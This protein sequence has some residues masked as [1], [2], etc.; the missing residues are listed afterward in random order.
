MCP[1]PTGTAP[2]ASIICRGEIRT[3]LLLDRSARKREIRES[4]QEEASALEQSLGELQKE[5]RHRAYT[6]FEH[7][8]ST[9]VTLISQA[10]Y[11]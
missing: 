2:R 3:P 11:S 9:R 10:T 4:L 5:Q 1:A 6:G 7:W 8:L